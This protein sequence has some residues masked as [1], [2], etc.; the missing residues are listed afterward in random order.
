MRL[1]RNQLQLNYMLLAFI[2]RQECNRHVHISLTRQ[3]LLCLSLPGLSH[4]HLI[5][6]PTSVCF[7]LW[8]SQNA[9][10]ANERAARRL[11][12]PSSL[13]RQKNVYI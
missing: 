13:Q 5:S 9:A 4:T 11:Q 1:F 8:R 12:E 10:I 3:G 2:Q 7:S 6:V